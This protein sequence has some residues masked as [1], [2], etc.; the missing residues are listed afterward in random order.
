MLESLGCTQYALYLQHDNKEETMRLYGE[1][2]I[3]AL[4]EPVVA[5]A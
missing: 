5:T 1:R 4:A 2:V 3:P